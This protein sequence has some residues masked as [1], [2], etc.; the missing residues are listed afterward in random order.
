MPH[1]A[2]YFPYI[3]IPSTAWTTQAILY[4]DKLASIV[5]LDYLHNPEQMD[6]LTRTLL[7]EGLVEAVIPEM[8]IHQVEKFDECFIEHLE[9]RVLHKRSYCARMCNT[10]SN[11]T[12]IHVEKMGGIIGFLVESGLAEWVDSNWYDVYTPVANQFMAYLATV[13]SSVP[14]VNAT[15]ITDKATYAV[16]LGFRR[17]PQRRDNSLHAFKAREVILKSL[18]PVPVDPDVDSLIRF[19]QRYGALLPPLRRKIEAHCAVISCLPDPEARIAATEIFIHD[20]E[21]HVAEIEAAMRPAF[22]AVVFGSLVPLFGSGLA[23][24]ATDQGNVVAYTGSA[25][26]LVGAAYQAIASI[27]GPR[28]AQEAKPLAYI[29][30]ARRE[31]APNH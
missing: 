11:T 17:P 31:L 2:L 13:L 10:R 26:S 14:S 18:L 9:A 7:S 15:P 1:N 23:L 12:R 19:K 8:F 3:D 29:A 4:W 6:V 27:R 28:L 21:D 16:S 5:P 20:C 22:G 24:Q 25:L 30:R